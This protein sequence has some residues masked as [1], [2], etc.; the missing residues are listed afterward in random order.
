MSLKNSIQCLIN[1][2]ISLSIM[3]NF[4]NLAI[5]PSQNYY[6]KRLCKVNYWRSW[7][8]SCWQSR[9]LLTLHNDILSIKQ[10]LTIKKLWGHSED[11]VNIHLWVAICTYLIVAYVK[12]TLKSQL[13][14]YEVMQIIS[15]SAFDKTPVK[16]LLTEFQDNQNIK[17]QRDLFNSNI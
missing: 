5:S 13:T 14:I 1:W 7:Q 16:E 17:E 11:A 2:L 12:Y 4:K 3:V 6:V 8:L 10:N 9:I 15:I